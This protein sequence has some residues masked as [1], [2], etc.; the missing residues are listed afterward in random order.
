MFV[1]AVVYTITGSCIP[2]C[3]CAG[4]IQASNWSVAYPLP[5]LSG[6]D[7]VDGLLVLQIPDAGVRGVVQE[8]F[9]DFFLVDF[10]PQGGSH[11]QSCITVSLA[12]QR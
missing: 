4:E 8:Q 5:L 7:Q 3:K 9:N 1:P 10:I 11:V 2:V 6:L 12:P